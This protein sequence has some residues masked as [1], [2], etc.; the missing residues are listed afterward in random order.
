MPLRG[1]QREVN[2]KNQ[3]ARKKSAVGCSFIDRLPR[4]SEQLAARIA[5]AGRMT[6]LHS[7]DVFPAYVCLFISNRNRNPITLYP[8]VT[9]IKDNF[10][11]SQ[12]ARQR[13]V[14]PTNCTSKLPF[15]VTSSGLSQLL[16]SKPHL[17]AIQM[18]N[19]C[20]Q[21][22]MTLNQACRYIDKQYL[23]H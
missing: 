21:L 17:F 20:K 10:F 22:S 8:I 15:T 12:S 13:T 3:Q 11:A 14:Y 16:I 23:E 2:S 19:V 7:K 18:P 4:C 9:E 5:S 6:L 1:L